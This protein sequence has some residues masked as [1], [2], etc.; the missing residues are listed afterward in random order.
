MEEWDRARRVRR[1]SQFLT[2]DIQDK[3][4]FLRQLAFELSSKTAAS[5]FPTDL[6]SEVFEKISSGFEGIE[7]EDMR[8]LF[9]ELETHTGLFLYAGHGYE[10]Q[11]KTMQEFL[12]ALHLYE[13][14]VVPTDERFLLSHPNELALTV[15]FNDNP[16]MYLA[17]L[18]MERF[19]WSF[20]DEDFIAVFL[21]RLILEE[22]KFR[23]H[24]YL[25]ICAIKIYEGIRGYNAR[26]KRSPKELLAHFYRL[27]EL[28]NA[29]GRSLAQLQNSYEIEGFD[30]KKK[31]IR[32]RWH[33]PVD[34]ALNYREPKELN[35]PWDFIGYLAPDGVG[36]LNRLSDD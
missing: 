32:L 16:T 29:I 15:S 6:V 3:K 11:H 18:V 1:P 22:V 20:Y 34:S 9:R 19:E 23:I 10:F 25:G 2:F 4:R 31:S 36:S 8:E 24:P 14:P 33:R 28:D 13:F 27:L 17:Y 26:G 35:A 30:A 21:D 12:F 5:F 7:G